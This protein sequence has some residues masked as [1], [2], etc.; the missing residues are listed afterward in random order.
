MSHHHLTLYST[1]KIA[2]SYKSY[3]LFVAENNVENYHRQECRNLSQMCPKCTTG[4]YNI[5][6]DLP[7]FHFTMLATL[8][9]LTIAASGCP[10]FGSVCAGRPMLQCLLLCPEHTAQATADHRH[11]RQNMAEN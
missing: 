5:P 6:Y 9:C 3:R 8:Y 4:Q 2:I 7:V 11:R 1:I 10:A